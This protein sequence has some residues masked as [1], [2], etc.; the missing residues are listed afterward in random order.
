MKTVLVLGLMVTMSIFTHRS[1][2]GQS[3][4]CREDE[5]KRDLI[6]VEEHPP[7]A[8]DYSKVAAFK[9]ISRKSSYRID[10]MISVDMAILN[11]SKESI[12]VSKLTGF[13]LTLTAIDESG[14]KL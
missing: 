14:R 10:E 2:L 13:N 3:N 8:I 4:E 12:F 6:G 7:N 1:V 5:T 11:T 9:L